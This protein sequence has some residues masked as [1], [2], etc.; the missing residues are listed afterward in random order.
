[1]AQPFRQQ[2]R[3]SNP[4]CISPKTLLSPAQKSDQQCANKGRSSV[5]SLGRPAR[6]YSLDQQ[7]IKDAWKVTDILGIT[8][9]SQERD[10]RPTLDELDKL[11]QHF[12][13]RSRRRPA[14]VPMNRIIAFAIF[15]TRRHEDIVRITWTDLDTENSRCLVRDMKHPG[16]KIGNNVG[17]ISTDRR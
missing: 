12:A 5:F 10:R 7:A 1:M 16:K 2:G 11:M 15:S 17:V 6:N 9:K 13:D 4:L 3:P 14:S 8:S